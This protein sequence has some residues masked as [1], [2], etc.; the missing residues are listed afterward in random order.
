MSRRCETCAL[1]EVCDGNCTG[2]EECADVREARAEYEERKADER[3]RGANVIFRHLTKLR[4]I[5][6]NTRVTLGWVKRV[7]NPEGVGQRKGQ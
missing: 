2:Y 3:G 1:S 5:C 6:Y 4:K 7:P